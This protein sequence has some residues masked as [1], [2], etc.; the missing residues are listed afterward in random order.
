M[1]KPK[2]KR[3][4]GDYDSSSFYLPKQLNIDVEIARLNLKKEGFTFD[5]SDLISGLLHEWLNNP[6]PMP[7]LDT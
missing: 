1:A 7:R 6:R 3:G 4:N 2:R 5:R